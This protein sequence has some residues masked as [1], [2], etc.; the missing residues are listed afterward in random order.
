MNASSMGGGNHVMSCHGFVSVALLAQGPRED[1]FSPPTLMGQGS[2]GS[3]VVTPA[4]VGEAPESGIARRRGGV[5]SSVAQALEGAEGSEGAGAVGH[6][7]REECQSIGHFMDPTEAELSG[8]VYLADVFAWVGVT[9]SFRE[10][11]DIAFGKLIMVREIVLIPRAAWDAAVMNL[12][13]WEKKEGDTA[14]PPNVRPPR[15]V[16]LGQVES[17][18]RV[19][20]LRLGLTATEADTMQA[21]DRTT[22]PGGIAMAAAAGA[23]REIKLSVYIT[24]LGTTAH[25]GDDVT[26]LSRGSSSGGGGE[27]IAVRK[28]PRLKEKW[29]KP[30]GAS[31]SPP[32]AA[33]T[34]PKGKG[35]SKDGKGNCKG[36]AQDGR[37][38]SDEHGKPL[39]WYWNHYEEGCSAVC[40]QG[41]GHVC[42]FCWD[43]THRSIQCP[44]RPAGWQPP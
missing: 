34:P 2:V 17:L 22:M 29:K 32:R 1:P 35:K 6:R 5:Q 12:V 23:A 21:E 43:S 16:E 38:L 27:P 11:L 42:E 36:L 10:A 26:G 15:A 33:G 31:Q 20:R 3:G 4:S 40:G 24:H 25:L 7:G 39:C 13:I 37:Y 30:K 9:D 41:R 28:M 18:R 19:C 14:Q 44:Q 8:M